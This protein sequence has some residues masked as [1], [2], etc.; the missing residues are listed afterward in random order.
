[1]SEPVVECCLSI[2]PYVM[3]QGGRDRALVRR[4]FATE[5]PPAIQQRTLKGDTTRHV[6]AVLERNL[7]F[8]R[9]MLLDGR[10]VKEGLIVSATLEQALKRSRIA[11]GK[12]ASG[13]AN[14]LAAELWLARLE[15]ALA[16]VR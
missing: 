15:R 4:A 16:G 10:L 2:A 9:A 1:A 3:T 5:L 8:I 13:L 7:D 12:T 14:C 6:T 11:D